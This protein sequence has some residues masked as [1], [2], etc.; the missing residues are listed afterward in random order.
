MNYL[1]YRIEYGDRE[2]FFETVDRCITVR[3]KKTKEN[4]SLTQREELNV[5][6]HLYILEAYEREGND[7]KPEEIFIVDEEEDQN[8]TVEDLIHAIER[9]KRVYG[10]EN[11]N[12]LD[13]R[14][15]KVRRITIRPP[16]GA[17]VFPEGW[18]NYPDDEKM[19]LYLD[20][21]GGKLDYLHVEV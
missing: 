12:I 4:V 19:Q 14:I 3:D 16:I 6:L 13:P 8:E 9:T 21:I 15:R 18:Q 20:F 2:I 1:E 17:T 5:L 11:I 7:S 10:L